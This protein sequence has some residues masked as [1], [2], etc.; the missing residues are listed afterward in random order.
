MVF[1]SK[2][3]NIDVNNFRYLITGEHP[4]PLSTLEFYQEQTLFDVIGGNL[5][6]A[7]TSYSMV[8]FTGNVIVNSFLN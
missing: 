6:D 4:K 1:M 3:Y 7:D 2:C 5:F 8:G